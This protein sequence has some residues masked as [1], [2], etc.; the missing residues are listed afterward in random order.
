MVDG[1]GQL[2]AQRATPQ[3]GPTQKAY[4][5]DAISTDKRNPKANANGLLYGAPKESRDYYPCSIRCV[6]RLRG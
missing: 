4:L 1:L 5:H 3:I 2:G 6:A